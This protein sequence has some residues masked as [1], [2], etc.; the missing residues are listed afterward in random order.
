[1]IC[2][3]DFPCYVSV[4][5]LPGEFSFVKTSEP[6]KKANKSDILLQ[7]LY[8]EVRCWYITQKN[9]VG[10]DGGGGIMNCTLQP[11]FYGFDQSVF[12]VSIKCFSPEKHFSFLSVLVQVPLNTLIYIGN[13]ISFQS[14]MCKITIF[15]SFH[16][17]LEP[18]S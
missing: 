9:Q 12:I 7:V 15:S 14:K 13:C 6:T 10:Y 17:L 1:M 4:A 18:Y 16:L 5:I 11:I 8:Y 3:V 2:R